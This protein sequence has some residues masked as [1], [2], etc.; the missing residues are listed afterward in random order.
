MRAHIDHQRRPTMLKQRC[1]LVGADAGPLKGRARGHANFGDRVEPMQQPVEQETPD[2]LLQRLGV[3]RDH[4]G[5]QQHA[6]GAVKFLAH[7]P[8]GIEPR[9]HEERRKCL[10]QCVGILCAAALL[11]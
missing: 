5:A 9:F 4:A 11:Q 3:V 2:P 8:V 7:A 10:Q 1:R 6:P